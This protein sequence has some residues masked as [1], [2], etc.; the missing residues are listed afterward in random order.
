VCCAANF[1]ISGPH[2]ILVLAPI[3]DLRE[4][5]IAREAP[6][7]NRPDA[8]W[9]ALPHRLLHPRRTANRCARAVCSGSAL[10]SWPRRV[11][12]GR[13]TAAHALLRR[14]GVFGQQTGASA[15]MVAEFDAAQVHHPSIIRDFDVLPFSGCDRAGAGRRAIRWPGAGPCPNRDRGAPSQKAVLRHAVSAHGTPSPAATFS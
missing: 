1:V 6:V 5:G 3:G 15:L 10:P 2:V 8:V 13:G 12:A 4:A 14:D 9:R 7:P 11:V